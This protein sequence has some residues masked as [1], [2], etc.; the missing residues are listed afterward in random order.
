VLAETGS[1]EKPD[2]WRWRRCAP[3]LFPALAKSRLG[4]AGAAIIVSAA[5]T[6]LHVD[7]TN[8]ALAQLFAAGPLLTWMLVRT[9][10]L[11]VPIL[12][13]VLFNSGVSFA[14]IVLGIP[15]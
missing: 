9:G 2:A 10:S 1:D 11:R 7:R 4:F 6:S 12:C 8:L 5:W 14:V 13:H 3:F 15:E